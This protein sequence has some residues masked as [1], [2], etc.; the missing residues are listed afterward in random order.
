MRVGELVVR[1]FVNRDRRWSAR[2][3]GDDDVAFALCGCCDRQARFDREQAGAAR[4]ITRERRTRERHAVLRG[5]A[6][7]ARQHLAEGLRDF[8][9]SALLANDERDARLQF[10]ARDGDGHERFL[11]YGRQVMQ[12]DAR[13]RLAHD[14][15]VP[16]G[17]SRSA[18][19][20]PTCAIRARGHAEAAQEC[21]REHLVTLKAALERDVEDRAIAEHEL[22]GG[23]IETHAR[24]VALRRLAGHAPKRAMQLERRAACALRERGERDVVG[25]FRRREHV[26]HERGGDGHRVTRHT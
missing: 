11:L 10:L 20:E 18:T 5:P 24:R 25:E 21:A 8:R 16:R 14:G 22:R 3:L 1:A 26:Q 23:A 17:D 2:Q 6:E 9:R 15:G 12:P 7:H 19:D 13:P 4:Q